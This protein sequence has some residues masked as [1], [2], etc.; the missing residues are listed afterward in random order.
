MFYLKNINDLELRHDY[1]FYKSFIF[2]F[3][4]TKDA[5]SHATEALNLMT[6]T[7]INSVQQFD[8]HI[9]YRNTNSDANDISD[10]FRN[11]VDLNPRENF[12]NSNTPLTMTEENFKK[13]QNKVNNKEQVQC[14]KFNPSKHYKRNNIPCRGCN[15]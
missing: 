5:I 3:S 2:H 7:H 8:T 6:N 9:D 11:V 1:N 14:E 13:T 4:N 15:F 10:T 12:T